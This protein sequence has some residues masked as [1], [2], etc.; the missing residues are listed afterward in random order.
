[1]RRRLTLFLIGL[2]RRATPDGLVDDLLANAERSQQRHL[3][4]WLGRKDEG[5]GRNGAAGE[6]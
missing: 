5:E 3:D 1:M 4:R 6:I 2:A